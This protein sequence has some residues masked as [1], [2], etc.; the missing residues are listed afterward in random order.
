M[1]KLRK[2]IRIFALYTRLF[3]FILQVNLSYF[4]HS[5]IFRD[6]NSTKFLGSFEFLRKSAKNPD[7]WCFDVFADFRTADSSNTLKVLL[8]TNYK[9]AG[10]LKTSSS[11]Y[12]NSQSNL[13]I[14]ILV[15]KYLADFRITIAVPSLY[16]ACLYQ[17]H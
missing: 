4:I 9:I 12:N 2:K 11:K 7:C 15:H 8:L 16:Y 13:R 6:G 1:Q 17:C 14:R 10:Q 3:I 5:V